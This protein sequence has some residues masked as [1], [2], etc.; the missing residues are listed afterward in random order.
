MII[1]EEA[2]K[3]VINSAVKVE[4]EY[5][6]LN[7]SLNR[8]LAKDVISDVNSPPFDKSAMDGYA[9]R[10]EDIHNE[11]QIIEVIPAGIVPEKRIEK[12]LC[13]KIMTGAMVPDGAD[14]VLMVEYT[15]NISKNKI[16]FIK[17]STKNNIAYA[18]EDVKQGDI[19]LKKG[20]KIKAQHIAVMATT[21]YIKPL[22]AKK[23]RVGIISTGN[24]IVEPNIKP[25]LS[26][27]RNSNAYQLIAQVEQAGA[28]PDYIGIAKDD[29]ESSYKL[30]VDAFS[31]NQ[32]VLLTGGV[33]MGD[34]DFIPDI[35]DDLNIDIKFKT[36]AIQPG[37]PTVFGIKGNQFVFGLP[38]NPVS[39]FNIFELLV[40]PFLNKMMGA[41][42]YPVEIKMPLGKEYKRK[43]SLR[44]SFIP[45]KISNGNVW[46]LEYH[47][48]A[49]IFS[50]SEA[51]GIISI[52][53]GKTIIKKGEIVDVRQI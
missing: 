52:P 2:Y 32:L 22:V 39:S 35:L 15:E 34:F 29:K 41:N 38:G 27:I 20:T 13:S 19:V 9:C 53:V 36:I 49:H 1:F 48:S 23:V 42:F 24:E 51:D 10:R 3:L 6:D 8:I 45:I 40:K 44:K 5:V 30:I 21:G 16:K 11:L 47:G 43:K 25:G 33:S 14:C 4:N 26:Q 28:I 18:T 17:E 50:F 37:K 46:P 12:N 31:R 7:N